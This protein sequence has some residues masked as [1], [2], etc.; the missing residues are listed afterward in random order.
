[1]KTSQFPFTAFINPSSLPFS[2]FLPLNEN[3]NNKLNAS[4]KD[5]VGTF[6]PK[7]GKE[8]NNLFNK[9][10]NHRVIAKGLMGTTLRT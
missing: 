1:M 3:V 2:V 10:L 7:K 4:Q 5:S 8:R 9:S 6:K